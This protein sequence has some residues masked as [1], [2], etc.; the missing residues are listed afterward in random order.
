MMTKLA[1]LSEVIPHPT[2]NSPFR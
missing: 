1:L 2:Q